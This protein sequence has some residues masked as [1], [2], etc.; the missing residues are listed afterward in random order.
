MHAGARGG[1]SEREKSTSRKVSIA[2]DGEPVR[3]THSGRKVSVAC[4][5]SDTPKRESDGTTAEHDPGRRLTR[6]FDGLPKTRRATAEKTDK[7]PSHKKPTSK[8]LSDVTA[9]S[10]KRFKS[11]LQPPAAARDKVAGEMSSIG[12]AKALKL[13]SEWAAGTRTVSLERFHSNGFARTVSL[14]WFRSNGLSG[15]LPM[16]PN[17]SANPQIR[18]SANPQILESLDPLT[19][20]RW[21][22]SLCRRG[23]AYEWA[24]HTTQQFSRLYP[25]G[26]RIDS[27]NYD[28]TPFWNC[29]VQMT[30]I[31]YQTYDSAM[32]INNA[33]FLANGGCGYVLKPP[34]LRLQSS[35]GSLSQPARY[36]PLIAVNRR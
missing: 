10:G 33:K 15:L 24:Q 18:K 4:D 19:W 2:C 13:L 25:R 30:A 26:R 1:G 29:G 14:E 22:R 36:S 23:R 5:G 20:K 16:P 34:Y 9:I 11:F 32:Q 6:V 21:L 27:S 7:K 28:P 8:M 12:E 31:N 3:E 35:G 17:R